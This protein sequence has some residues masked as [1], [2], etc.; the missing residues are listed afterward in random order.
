MK[1]KDTL[2]YLLE[3]YGT[4]ILLYCINEDASPAQVKDAI[5]KRYQAEIEYYDPGTKGSKRRVIQPVAYGLSKGNNPVVRAFQP[6]GDTRSESPEWKMFR[7]DRIRSWKAKRNN[8]FNEP[9]GPNYPHLKDKKYNPDGD[10][11]MNVVYMNAD[12]TRKRMR[13]DAILKY[14]AEV[15]RKK[16]EQD[17]Y[18]DFKRNV[19]N[20]ID[21]TPEIIKRMRW[22]EE[23]KQRKRQR[24]LNKES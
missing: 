16:L 3:K 1:D 17:P 10:K 6:M 20:A 14:N 4:D 9:P 19:K 18:Y 11:G 24:K 8:R 15:K 7:L 5:K 21:A 13:N 12:F 2:I 22:A 23:D